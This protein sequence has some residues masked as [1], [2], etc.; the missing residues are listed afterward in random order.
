M[1]KRQ[2]GDAPAPAP[3]G[4]IKLNVA[5]LLEKYKHVIKT[6]TSAPTTTTTTAS[7]RRRG[8]KKRSRR[9][10][11]YFITNNTKNNCLIKYH[12]LGPTTASPVLTT[13]RILPAKQA[14]F[15]VVG[16]ASDKQRSRIQIKKGPNGQEYEYEYVYYYYDDD[17]D[18]K[19]LYTPYQK[20]SLTQLITDNQRA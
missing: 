16:S 13:S 8:T 4:A 5:Q 19:V 2:A 10:G 1:H 11:I 15:D 7:S 14:D 20:N 9:E 6:S 17:D 18:S 3:P 12:Y